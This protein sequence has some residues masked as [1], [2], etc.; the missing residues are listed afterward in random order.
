MYTLY[1][2]TYLKLQ[3]SDILLDSIQ[4]NDFFFIIHKH[5]I[6]KF[7]SSTDAFNSTGC[8]YSITDDTFRIF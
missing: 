4:G 1:F 5:L 8:E 7:F 3:Y 2:H 6:Q